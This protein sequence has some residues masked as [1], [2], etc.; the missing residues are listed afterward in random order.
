VEFTEHFFLAL[1]YVAALGFL[2]SGLDDLFFDSQFLVYLWKIRKRA[3]LPLKE[4]RLAQEQ[5]IALLVPAWQEGG[6]V[7]KMAEYATRVV[8]YEKYDIFIGVY[9]NDPETN[10]CVDEICLTHPRIHKV[11]VPHPGPTSKA[12][13]LNWIYR[14]MRLNEVPGVR[15]YAVVAIHDAEDVLHPLMLKVYNYFVPRHHDMAQLPVFGLEFPPWKN[16]VANTYIDDFAELHTKDLYVRQSIGGVVPSAGVG[17]AFARPVLERLSAERGG[18]PFFAGNLTEDYEVGI[19]VKRA[20]YRVGVVNVPVERL[21]RPRRADGSL[22]RARPV[23]ELVAVRETF[24][25]TFSNAVRQRARWI[26][27]ISFQTWEQAGWSGTWPVRYT[28]ARD[29]R[30][31]LT[32]LINMLGYLVLA[33][34]LA[35]WIFRSTPWGANFYLRPVFISESW[36]WKVVL[37]DTWLLLY[38]AAQKFISVTA[39]YNWRQA[40]ASIPRV[41]VNNLV[42]FTATVRAAGVYLAHKFFGRPIVWFKTEHTFPA[43]AELAEYT[44]TIEDLLVQEGLVTREQLLDAVRQSNGYSVPF[45]LLRMGLLAEEDFTAIWVKHSGLDARFVDPYA[46]PGRLLD[47]C[48]EALALEL[49]AIP[50]AQEGGRVVVAFREPPPMANLDRL[51]QK[52]GA[53]VV[54]VL[55]RPGNLVYA[56]NRAYPRHT[57]ARSPILHLPQRFQRIGTLDALIFLDAL[58]SQQAGRHSLPDVITDMALLSEGEARLLW[59]D[60][61]GCPPSQLQPLTVDRDAYF[62]VGPFFWWL[63][64]ILPVQQGRVVCAALRH[65]QMMAWLATRLGSEPGWLA[66]LPRKLELASQIAGSGLD[67]EALVLDSLGDKGV[68]SADDIARARAARALVTDPIPNWLLLQKLVTEEQLN[69]AFREICYLPRADEWRPEEVRRLAPILPPG[70]AEEHGC[71][72]LEE[73]GAAVRLGLSQLPTPQTVHEL[74]DRLSGCSLFFQSVNYEESRQLKILASNS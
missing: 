53:P 41:V 59:A 35:Q 26:L 60:L 62:R 9:L 8:L 69:E 28:L 39:I 25:S 68:L 57:L 43:E 18:E 38:R 31:P 67:P 47:R 2:V 11:V 10:R 15:E 36:L 42:N 14:A 6:V 65:P 63:H 12:D 48:P 46:I 29:R 21:V 58:S 56:R 19:R 23:T 16:W 17:T 40:V 71:Y 49:A 52:L 24:P 70:F 4:L 74:Y 61:L 30:A 37:I 3:P 34:A 55:A 66:E 54:P 7:N 73:S 5:W 44:K 1:A 45:V 32:H 27:G 20:G 13:C 72:C 64:R 50:V 51:R 22:G 33:F